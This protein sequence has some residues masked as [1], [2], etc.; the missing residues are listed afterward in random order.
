MYGR[1][2]VWSLEHK[3]LRIIGGYLTI[4]FHRYCHIHTHTGHSSDSSSSSIDWDNWY[5]PKKD[6]KEV[7]SLGYAWRV[8]RCII[9]LICPHFLL[10]SD[11]IFAALLIQLPWQMARWQVLWSGMQCQGVWFRQWWLWNRGSSWGNTIVYCHKEGLD[12]HACHTSLSAICTTESL[13]M[14]VALH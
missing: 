2:F 6:E 8:R 5:S 12:H 14:S 1:K 9:D 13:T 3:S 4:I 11:M 10:K 7:G